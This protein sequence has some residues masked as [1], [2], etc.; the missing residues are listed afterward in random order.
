MS[1]LSCFRLTPLLVAACLTLHASF[2]GAS[3]FLIDYSGADFLNSAQAHGYIVFDD[4]L[5]PNPTPTSPVS[6]ALL[7]PGVEVTGFS[8]TISGAAAGNG[9]FTLSDYL[10]FSWDTAGVSLDL[11]T[12][13]VG[14]IIGTAG[15]W[16]T[17]HDGATGDFNFL[18]DLTTNPA[19]PTTAGL[20]FQIATD[21]GNG[22][23]LNLSS[24]R[25]LPEPA[26]LWL[27]GI[28]AGALAASRNKA[29]R[30]IG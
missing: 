5:L 25:R 22:D 10:A 20:A 15:G 14:Q 1:V 28:G 23:T 19:A 27:L 13:L 6:G 18:T 17:T 2:A 29:L 26:S 11:T 24:M 7:F 4:A 9:T 12:E 30:R 3:T 16:G 8:L 21:G